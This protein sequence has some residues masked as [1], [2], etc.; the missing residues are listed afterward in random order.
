MNIGIV[1]RDGSVV[2]RSVDSVPTINEQH[3]ND[4]S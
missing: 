1:C 4:H 3:H 2:L